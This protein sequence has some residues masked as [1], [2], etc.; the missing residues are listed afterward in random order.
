MYT[1]D[2]FYIQMGRE[3]SKGCGSVTLAKKAMYYLAD[4]VRVVIRNP[5]DQLVRKKHR[6]EAFCDQITKRHGLG[7]AEKAGEE[8]RS[9]PA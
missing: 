5:S 3:C 1:D 4:A 9:D 8:L 7:A 6:S 2:L